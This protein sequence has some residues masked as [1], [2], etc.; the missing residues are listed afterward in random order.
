MNKE[1]KQITFFRNWYDSIN[2]VEDEAARL[3]LYDAIFHYCFDGEE[4]THIEQHK[5]A[6]F[7]WRFL[8]PLLKASRRQFLNGIKSKGA[9]KG[10]KNAKKTGREESVGKFT[11]P[12]LEDIGAY[13]GQMCYNSDPEGFF[14]YNESVGW[15]SAKRNF[16]NWKEAADRWERNR[17]EYH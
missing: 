10:N 15:K 11:I 8:L 3:A 2:L 1:R 4:P 13:F 9:P 7:V 6:N 5:E 16:S 14:D 12:T 17:C